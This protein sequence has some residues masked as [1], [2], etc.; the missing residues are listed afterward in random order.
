MKK[1]W[2]L[3]TENNNDNEMMLSITYYYQKYCC[4]LIKTY[5]L[6]NTVKQDTTSLLQLPEIE[7][8]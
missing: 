5:T 8:F 7:G 4:S 3:Q 6:K 1:T 2:C